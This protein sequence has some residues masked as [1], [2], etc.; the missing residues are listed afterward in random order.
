[1]KHIIFDAHPLKSSAKVYQSHQGHLRLDCVA[2]VA[3]VLRYYDSTG[4]A[5][6][7]LRHPDQILDS[8]SVATLSGLPI[9]ISHPI[10]DNKYCLVTPANWKKY[11]VGVMGDSIDI[12]NPY[13]KVNG[14]SIHDNE[15]LELLQNGS[16]QLSP[17]YEGVIV[18]EEG[19]F[20][21][22]KY[23]HRQYPITDNGVISYNHVAIMD[24]NES[25]R[26]GDNAVFL[27][28]SEQSVLVMDS[29]CDPNK[30][31]HLIKTPWK[32]KKTMKSVIFDGKDPKNPEK[33]LINA[34]YQVDEGGMV[35]I[36]MS[37]FQTIVDLNS[38]QFSLLMNSYNVLS[39]MGVESVQALVDSYKEKDAALQTAT[40]EL[41][42]RPIVDSEKQYT[43]DD[44]KTHSK[45]IA[46][47]SQYVDS[48]VDL[49]VLD[50]TEI[51]KELIKV[52]DPE[53][54]IDSMDAPSING[55]YT[56][57]IKEIAK[58]TEN[59]K[60]QARV[61]SDSQQTTIVSKTD[62]ASIQANLRNSRKRSA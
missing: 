3:G 49:F 14:C 5:M 43:I 37:D 60:N 4:K 52:Y 7:V 16:K 56:V 6:D 53:I 35:M 15:A 58:R 1:M 39:S 26:N 50:S 51:K 40:K 18:P 55:V 10:E 32:N 31:S 48:S 25:G 13:V 57:A 41:E 23:T 61:I 34:A 28:D 42:N 45:L 47:V 8:K 9:T 12:V 24:F 27:L 59:T 20:D 19:V 30:S 2:T 33:T 17:G 36:P 22:R 62:M 21:G 38:M 54:Q 11:G 29:E 44:L 46:D